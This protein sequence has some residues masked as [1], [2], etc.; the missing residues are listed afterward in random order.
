MTIHWH[1]AYHHRDNYPQEIDIVLHPEG[2]TGQ[3]VAPTLTVAESSLSSS[4]DMDEESRTKTAPQR[5]YACRVDPLQD[6]RSIELTNKIN[7]F[8]RPHMRAFHCAWFCYFM[9]FCIWF[10][11]SP[12]LSEIQDDLNLSKHQIWSSSIAGV[13][14]TIFMRFVNGPLCDKY[15]PRIV[16]SII[17]GSASIPTCCI[18]L[19]RNGTDLL[20]VRMF[21]GISGST[22]V[23]CQYWC[24][25]MFAREVVG[26][27]NAMAGGWG[28]LGGAVTQ[29]MV[30]SVLFPLFKFVFQDSEIAWRSVCIVPAV[31]AM[32]TSYWIV[33]NSED[34]PKGNYADL[35]SQSDNMN[36]PNKRKVSIRESFFSGLNNVNTWLLFVQY[37][38]CFGVEITMNNAAALYFKDEFGQSTESA[39]AIA[40]IFGWMNLFARG[41][42]GY[43]SDYANKKYG[44]MRGRLLTQSTLLFFE[45]CL[46][47]CFGLIHSLAGAIICMVCFSVFVQAAEGS[48]Y[49]IVPY[50]ANTQR[51]QSKNKR[52]C[53]NT[54]SIAGIVGAGGNTGAVCFSLF[55]RE[56]EYHR[57]FVC[58]G[59]IIVLSSLLSPFVRIPGQETLM[60]KPIDLV[61]DME[62]ESDDIVA[63]GENKQCKITMMD[64]HEDVDTDEACSDE[65]DV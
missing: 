21:I 47:L 35:K 14:S 25:R 15:G 11:V 18:G 7:T 20:V 12:L 23:M 2:E 42:G 33:G 46:V 60:L 57:A 39:A 62:Y 41:M 49:G 8:E 27:A 37:A 1:L 19:I 56:M 43:L 17:L 59:F 63:R 53:D 32:Y 30:G 64:D 22:F 40:S 26:T 61:R 52:S 58:M 16:M 3:E 6:D 31:I 48:S 45:G 38:C 36:V 50:I 29:L 5:T 28:N 55:F 65:S 24:T 13:G 51:N 9:A 10:S 4:S 44:G 34:S 54:G